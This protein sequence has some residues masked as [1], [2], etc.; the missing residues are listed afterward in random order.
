V[1]IEH[2]GHESPKELLEFFVKRSSIKD[3]INCGIAINLELPL[4]Q[5]LFLILNNQNYAQ[6]ECYVSCVDIK[7]GRLPLGR[8]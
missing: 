5:S 6:L 3:S 7:L 4:F 8:T 1:Y 2:N